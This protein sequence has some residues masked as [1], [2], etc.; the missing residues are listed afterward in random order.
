MNELSGHQFDI[1]RHA[2]TLAKNERVLKVCTLK[3]RLKKLYA[4]EDV[5]AAFEAWISTLEPVTLNSSLQLARVQN[6]GSVV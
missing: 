5:E 6:Q 3:D 2:I 1:L 4:A